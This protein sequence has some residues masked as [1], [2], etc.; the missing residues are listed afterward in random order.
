MRICTKCGETREILHFRNRPAC[1]DGISRMCRRCETAS[2]SYRPKSPE[3][4]KRY[5]NRNRA[6]FL[7]RYA[8][9]RA[10]GKG[11]EFDL[12]GYRTELQNRIDNGQ[13]ELTGYPFDMEVSRGFNTPSLDRIDSSKGYTFDNIRVVCL[14]INTALGTWGEDRLYELFESWASR[15]NGASPQATD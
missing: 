13:C 14:A 7:I 1:R 12:D 2:K 4:A 8:R 10:Q 5:R 11:W 9:E 15:K 6:Y 3:N